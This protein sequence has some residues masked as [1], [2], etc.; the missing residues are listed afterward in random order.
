MLT[1]RPTTPQG[2]NSAAAA[3]SPDISPTQDGEVSSDVEAK[4]DPNKP[5]NTQ[6]K[7]PKARVAILLISVFLCM[8]LV[9][10]DRTIIST[11]RASYSIDQMVHSDV[12]GHCATGPCAD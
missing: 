8:F 6:D 9:G 5:V 3:H 2:T 1:E 4:A 12:C 11:V 10:L 7:L